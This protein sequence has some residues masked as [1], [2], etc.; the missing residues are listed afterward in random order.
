[1]RRSHNELIPDR[2]VRAFPIALLA[3]ISAFSVGCEQPQQPGVPPP[4]TPAALDTAGW[5]RIELLP[6]AFSSYVF[7]FNDNGTIVGAETVGNAGPSYPFIYENGIVRRVPTD[8]PLP[9]VINSSGLLVGIAGED[10]MVAVWD[11]PDAMPRRLDPGPLSD[12]DFVRLVGVNDQGDIVVQLPG[13]ALLWR[14][15]ARQ[16]LGPRFGAAAVNERGQIVGSSTVPIVVDPS[17]PLPGEVAHPFLWENG[18]MRDLGVLAHVPCEDVGDCEWGGA[19]DI[20]EQGV[21]LGQSKGADG[22]GRAFI[23]ENGVIRDLGAFP[24]SWVYPLAINDRSQVLAYVPDSV[25]PNFFL[26]DHGQTQTVMRAHVRD[27]R[28]GPIAL[29][30]HGE[31]IGSRIVGYVTQAWVWEAGTVTELGPGTPV[32]INSRGDIIGNWYPGNGT[33]VAILWRKKR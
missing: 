31:V 12:R 25:S 4:D 10:R 20:N 1:M 9:S 26:W 5:E 14:N 29:G 17:S 19:T 27:N 28:A 33:S 6:D 21:V 30:P 2:A 24:G 15:G 23:W 8:G 32:A 18:V 16:D 11:S 13:R 22:V 7:D 3:T